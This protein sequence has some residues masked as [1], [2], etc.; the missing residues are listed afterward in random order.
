MGKIFNSNAMSRLITLLFNS[1]CTPL[2][3]KQI[4]LNPISRNERIF[5]LSDI[6]VCAHLNLILL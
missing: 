3:V 1:L 2:H 4:H 6:R 5:P